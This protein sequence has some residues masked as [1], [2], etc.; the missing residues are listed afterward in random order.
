MYQLKAASSSTQDD[1]Y[2]EGT[3]PF[4]RAVFLKGIETSSCF[5]LKKRVLTMH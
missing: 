3:W 4:P 2:G 5:F 1:D